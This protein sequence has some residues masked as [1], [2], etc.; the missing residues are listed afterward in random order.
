MVA[1]EVYR[2]TTDGTLGCNT[3]AGGSVGP[4]FE[5]LEFQT[6]R[7]L[8]A[9]EQPQA[10]S[11]WEPAYLETAGDT[12]W[13]LNSSSTTFQPDENPWDFDERE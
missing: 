4:D 10:G 1:T 11:V 8:A 6:V 13:N 3:Q 12:P 5:R 2:T 9:A 7:R